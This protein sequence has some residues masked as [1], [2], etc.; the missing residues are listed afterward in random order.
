M[1]ITFLFPRKPKITT[2]RT[3]PAKIVV[4][5]VHDAPG[6]SS[7]GRLFGYIG[8]IFGFM[9]KKVLLYFEGA[10]WH[11]KIV[12]IWQVRPRVRIFP[13]VAK[14][15]AKPGGGVGGVLGL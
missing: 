9:G 3:P 11:G 5:R 2:K 1:R 13:P 14:G 4:R 10:V 15:P 8:G 7:G 6:W 12:A